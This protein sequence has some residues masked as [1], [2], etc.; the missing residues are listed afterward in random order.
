MISEISDFVKENKMLAIIIVIALVL[1]SWWLYNNVQL[2]TS[3]LGSTNNVPNTE[4]KNNEKCNT[5]MDFM[6]EFENKLDRELKNKKNLSQEDHSEIGK[7]IN[8]VK[9]SLLSCGKPKKS[10]TDSD[11]SVDS[12]LPS[13]K[14][15]SPTSEDKEVTRRGKTTEL[16]GFD[17]NGSTYE[18]FTNIEDAY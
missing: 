4:P 15:D 3:L 9:G 10:K 8:K 13:E 2:K 11:K 6:S 1:G 17:I 5:M 7:A 16:E 18:T 12:D 14:A